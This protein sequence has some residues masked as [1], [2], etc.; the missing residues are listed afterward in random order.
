MTDNRHIWNV[1]T[2]DTDRD[3]YCLKVIRAHD[4][5]EAAEKFAYWYDTHGTSYDLAGC[6]LSID[7]VVWQPPA[8]SR[9]GQTF[10]VTGHAV[11][12]YTAQ[13]KK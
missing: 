2:A 6:G 13:E 10:T 9:E 5:Q 3:D 7:V 11:P 4:A 1:R 8:I 12:K